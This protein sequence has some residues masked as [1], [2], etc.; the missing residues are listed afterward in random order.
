MCTQAALEPC[1]VCPPASQSFSSSFAESDGSEFDVI[2]SNVFEETPILGSPLQS[3]PTSPHRPFQIN[4][5]RIR[6]GFGATRS[7][8]DIDEEVC[9]SCSFEVPEELTDDMVHGSPD[10]ARS[11]ASTR[12]CNPTLRTRSDIL[13]QS[14][15]AAQHHHKFIYTTSRQPSSPYLYTHLKRTAIRTLSCETLPRGS[16]SGPLLFGDDVAGYTIA[17]VFRLR[18]LRARGYFGT[19][20]LLALAGTDSYRVSRVL[21]SVTRVFA[22][23]AK[24]IAAAAESRLMA[25]ERAKET[26]L[27]EQVVQGMTPVSSFLSPR[28]GGEDFERGGPGLMPRFARFSSFSK[29]AKVAKGLVELVGRE[30]FFVELHVQFVR[31]LAMLDRELEG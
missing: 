25:E 9:A 23:I 30:G 12:R 15:I 2:P 26:V 3:P 5:D 8:G 27:E 24:W 28:R 7:E 17:Y 13:V 6:R 11:D 1:S 18:D 14:D 31:L 22:A 21:N 4:F 29:E 20:A 19:Y 10:S 16:R